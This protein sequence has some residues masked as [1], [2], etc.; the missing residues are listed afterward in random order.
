MLKI[1]KLVADYIDCWKPTR[2]TYAN[3]FEDNDFGCEH[4]QVFRNGFEIFDF[5]QHLRPL[6]KVWNNHN[7]GWEG[8]LL[9]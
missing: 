8:R 1:E 7:M 4:L 5:N 2:P 9:Q 6:S 3:I